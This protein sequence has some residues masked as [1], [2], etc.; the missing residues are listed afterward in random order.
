MAPQTWSDSA[1]VSAIRTTHLRAWRSSALME[2]ALPIATAVWTLRARATGRPDS[3]PQLPSELYGS[4]RSPMQHCLCSRTFPAEREQLRWAL[5]G[6]VGHGR[7]VLVTDCMDWLCAVIDVR[8]Y[9]YVWSPMGLWSRSCLYNVVISLFYTLQYFC[10]VF[11]S[12]WQTKL[13]IL[14]RSYAHYLRFLIKPDAN[15]LSFS[16]QLSLEMRINVGLWTN[17]CWW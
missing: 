10:F 1:A 4:S 7:M 6:R 13:L 17:I 11:F 16:H 5:S 3:T 14:Y 12:N 8:V 15:T 2:W 9:S